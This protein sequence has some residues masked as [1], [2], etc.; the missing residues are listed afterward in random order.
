[1]LHTHA[2]LV[3]IPPMDRHTRC[4][5][6]NASFLE[7]YRRIAANMR[8]ILFLLSL[9]AL[10]GALDTLAL[11]VKPPAVRLVRGGWRG[12]EDK[13]LGQRLYD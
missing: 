6:T 11:S 7:G 12:A 3:A 5:P 8:R 10:L 2:P 13:Q 9:V 1:M 4:T